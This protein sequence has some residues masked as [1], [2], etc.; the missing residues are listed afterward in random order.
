MTVNEHTLQKI[1]FLIQ[2]DWRLT[3][4]KTFLQSVLTILVRGKKT[5]PEIYFSFW[6]QILHR[7]KQNMVVL[8]MTY[9]C[10]T[11][12]SR[13]AF[14]AGVCKRIWSD[15]PEY[16]KK[17]MYKCYFLIKIHK[18]H[19]SND[20]QI[21]HPGQFNQPRSVA[22]DMGDRYNDAF[23]RNPIFFFFDEILFLFC[24]SSK[25]LRINPQDYDCWW[26]RFM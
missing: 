11:S 18:K 6:E 3:T 16:Q 12:N 8:M 24:S 4:S 22:C 5:M 2:N 19:V 25:Y 15:P 10:L 7:L 26:V 9:S 1:I 14:N 17:I 23:I 20:F 21:L 13:H